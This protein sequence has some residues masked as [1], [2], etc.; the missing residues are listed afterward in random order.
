MHQLTKEKQ[1]AEGDMEKSIAPVEGV[2]RVEVGPF[3]EGSKGDI[4]CFRAYV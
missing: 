1:R 2:Q 3:G 4:R